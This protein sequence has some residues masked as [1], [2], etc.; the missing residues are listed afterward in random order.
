MPFARTAGCL[1]LV[2][3]SMRQLQ[4]VTDLSEEFMSGISLPE[5]DLAPAF[6]P[7]LLISQMLEDSSIIQQ[8]TRS[9]SGD[10]ETVV[11]YFR[12]DFAQGQQ[13]AVLH[14]PFTPL[15]NEVPSVEA[16]IMDDVA[17]KVRVT[18]R[19]KFGLRLEVVTQTP[20]DTRCAVLIEVVATTC[21][22]TNE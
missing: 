9:R 15:L 20:V 2:R 16:M 17:G 13:R 8:V 22:E 4:G 1:I 10:S 18:D 12:C 6:D 19:Q 14:V 11:G 5:D 21:R 3:K 7:E